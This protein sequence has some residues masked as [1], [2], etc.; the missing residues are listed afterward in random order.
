MRIYR[1]LLALA[2]VLPSLVFAAKHTPLVTPAVQDQLTSAQVLKR[3][4]AGNA[5]F[6]KNKTHHQNFHTNRQQTAAQQ[7]PAAVILSCIDSRV[8]PEIVFD[9]GVGNVFV[10]RVAANVINKDILGGL[11]F[12]TAAAGAKLIVVMG[13]DSCGS[14]RGACQNVKLGNLTHLLNKVKPAVDQVKEKQGAVNCEKAHD[15]D[16]IAKQNVINVVNAIAKDSPV[17]AKLLDEHKIAIIGAMYHLSTG[18]V[19]FFNEKH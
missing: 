16:A 11:E 3:L 14:V 18:K 8:P 17:I 9:Q 19:S 12:A 10:S 15:V 6:V 13:H 5:R 4:K 1:P 2:L 7:H